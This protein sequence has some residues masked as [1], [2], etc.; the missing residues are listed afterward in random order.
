MAT[1]SC[2]STS[3]YDYCFFKKFDKRI[4]AIEYFKFV[5]GKIVEDTDAFEFG[6]YVKSGSNA[7]HLFIFLTSMVL[8]SFI[9]LL[10]NF[11]AH[12]DCTYKL[13]ERG[14]LCFIFQGLSVLTMFKIR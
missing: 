10:P 12:I 6:S 3:S 5:K 2:G 14:L 13:C 9:K 4:Q 1:S 11:P 7:N 8:I